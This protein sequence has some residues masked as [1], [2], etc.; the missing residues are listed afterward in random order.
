MTGPTTS[1]TDEIEVVIMT[2]SQRILQDDKQNYTEQIII[3]ELQ[4]ELSTK[5]TLQK[6]NWWYKGGVVIHEC[7]LDRN[8]FLPEIQGT[9]RRIRP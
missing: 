3:P 7:S 4:A 9:N 2:G 5:S 6:V 8:L 1:G